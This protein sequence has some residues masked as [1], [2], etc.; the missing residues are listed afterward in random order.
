MGLVIKGIPDPQSRFPRKWGQTSKGEESHFWIARVKVQLVLRL[1]K[2]RAEHNYL[3][4][5]VKCPRARS[6]ATENRCV[7]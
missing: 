3:K 1:P 7:R 4:S 6:Q 2:A 5:A